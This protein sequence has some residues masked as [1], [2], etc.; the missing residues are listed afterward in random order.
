MTR[1]AGSHRI[2]IAMF[3]AALSL[4]PLTVRAESI[5][6][7]IDSCVDTYNGDGQ[8]ELQQNCIN[9]SKNRV[10]YAAIAY[11][12]GSGETCAALAAG[13]NNTYAATLGDGTGDARHNAPAACARNGGRNCAITV[14][15]CA[16]DWASRAVSG[17]AG[18]A[19][20]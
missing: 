13:D 18:S 20:F 6:G 1:C 3:I 5:N 14:S 12:A 4:V 2:A 11:D 8:W 19:C 7:C 16:R 17:K 10:N 15:T 9:N